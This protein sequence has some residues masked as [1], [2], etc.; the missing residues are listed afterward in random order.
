[1]K[2][3]TIWEPSATF[4]AHGLKRYETRSWKTNY[5][6]F[7]A[8]HAAKR[9]NLEQKIMTEE[10]SRRYAELTRYSDYEFPLG[11]VVVAC[12]LVDVHRVEDLR[13]KLSRVEG[14]LGDYSNGRFAWELEI[15]KLPKKPIPATGQQGIWEW[16]YKGEK[17]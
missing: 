17:P 5:R 3:I 11:C 1:M 15:V 9:F 12:Y 7:I 6:G 10:L 2:A 16:D 13:P 14:A 4:I 8:I